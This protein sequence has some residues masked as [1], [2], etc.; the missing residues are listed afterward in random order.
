M[1]Q[2]LI[3]VMQHHW[4]Q[5]VFQQWRNWIRPMLIIV[6]V[7]TASLFGYL[8]FFCYFRKFNSET[9]ACRNQRWWDNHVIYVFV[10]VFF[11]DEIKLVCEWKSYNVR[12]YISCILLHCNVLIMVIYWSGYSYSFLVVKPLRSM[13]QIISFSYMAIRS[14]DHIDLNCR[15]GLRI[16]IKL[17]LI[18]WCFIIFA[19]DVDLSLFPPFQ[20]GAPQRTVVVMHSP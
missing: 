15:R 6:V 4:V 16:K 19:I 5:L 7:S 2:Q 1:L 12:G 13:K 11:I 8:T 3:V 18:C 10:L 14:L 20:V 17:T 9:L